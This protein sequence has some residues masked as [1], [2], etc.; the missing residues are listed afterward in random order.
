MAESLNKIAALVQPGA[1]LR[2]FPWGELRYQHTQAIR[3]QLGEAY[4]A[5]T[6]NRHLSALRGALKEAWRLGYMGA[7]DYQRAVDLKAVK[8]QKA[9]QG[10]R[11][12]A[13]L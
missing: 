8:G 12:V 10:W 11:A 13:D 9:A 6:A 4:S 1:D 5:A 3:A 2:T 7:E